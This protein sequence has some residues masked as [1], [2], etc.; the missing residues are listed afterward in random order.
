[1]RPMD[2]VIGY[3]NIKEE[4]YRLIDV[5]KNPSKYQKMGVEEPKGLML[6]GDP[7]IGKSLLAEC[8][9]EETGRKSFIIRKTRS[10]GD[11][12]NFIKNTF[13][14][15]KKAA[16]SV[17]LIDD[18]DRFENGDRDK[19]N[20]EAYIAIQSLIDEI[21]NDK[22]YVI[23][24]VNNE[25]LLPDSLCR[26]GR[27]DKKIY[28]E[29]PD[30]DNATKIVSHYLKNYPCDEDVNSE[31]IAKILNNESCATLKNVI[32]EAGIRATYKGKEKIDMDDILHACLRVIYKA[33]ECLENAI[34]DYV[35]SKAYHEAGHAVIKEILE[36][37]TVNI[38][39][40][41]KCEGDI[42]GIT[43]SSQDK[44]YYNDIDFMDN[45]ILMLL[46]GKAAIELKYGKIDTGCSSDIDR[47]FYIIERT[48]K[49][50]AGYNF[51]CYNE[52]LKENG[53]AKKN[54]E[55]IMAFKM[56]EYYS[57]AKR[58]LVENNDFL[59]KMTDLLVEK[60]IITY[61]DIIEL[62]KK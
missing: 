36:P 39:T 54:R 45:K 24:I 5:L 1:M 49:D 22:V 20:G 25:T 9:I 38:V 33:P 8:I 23:A 42:G 10:D 2:K 59:E 12:I 50:F 3:K 19:V 58:I 13:E 14:E 41:L 18:L 57:K 51:M 48:A 37:G 16:P 62:K 6:I 4:L 29:V 15:A 61:L 52:F 34:Y 31:F 35:R 32:N 30:G 44:N 46:G 28:M 21:K 56:E 53:W 60:K 40:V 17:I 27:F 43:S 47:A 7:G 11:F 55:Q 26:D